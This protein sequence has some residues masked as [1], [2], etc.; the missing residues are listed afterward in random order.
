MSHYVMSCILCDVTLSGGKFAVQYKV[1]NVWNFKH[2]QFSVQ[3]ECVSIWIV[4]NLL[5]TPAQRC[6]I[7]TPI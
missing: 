2:F 1:C 3:C 7:A 5:L 6:R 4:L